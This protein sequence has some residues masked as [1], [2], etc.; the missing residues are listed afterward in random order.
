MVVR[1][2]VAEADDGT[3]LIVRSRPGD[4]SL[5]AF[6]LVHGLSSN[7]RLW[8]G[9]AEG[10]EVTDHASFA[11]DLRGHGESEKPAHGYDFAGVAADV[12][13][14][15]RD[16]VGRR[17]ILVGQSWGA[18]VVV[19]AAGRFPEIARAVA[20]IDG[21]YISLSDS[22]ADWE[23]AKTQ[24]TPPSFSG[25]TEAQLRTHAESWFAGFPEAGVEAQ[26]ANFVLAED[27]TVRPRLALANHLTILEHL[28][29][30]DPLAAVAAVHVPVWVMAVHGGWDD[31]PRRVS[32]FVA[33]A[34]R[35]RVVWTDGHHDVHAQDPTRVVDFLLD[36]SLEVTG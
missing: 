11:V 22:F 34:S 3:R 16:V 18:N 21:G 36:L 26:L 28:W 24:L 5:P 27:G 13:A 29:T 9:V 14:V 25:F 31:K 1:T 20:C 12:A 35:S 19:E 4:P 15:V 23:A 32:D 7:A 6:L 33:A 17:A 8:D 2:S 10:L 30:H